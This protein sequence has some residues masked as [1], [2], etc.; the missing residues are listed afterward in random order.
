VTSQLAFGVGVDTGSCYVLRAPPGVRAHVAILTTLN[1]QI[2]PMEEQVNA[3]FG[4][5]RGASG[6]AAVQ[7]AEAPRR[8]T[9]VAPGLTLVQIIG[10]LGLIASTVLGL[11]VMVAISRDRV[12]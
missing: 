5:P 12:L 10:Y 3:H 1:A 6:A 4:R 9:L 11:R 2:M 8:H 7:C